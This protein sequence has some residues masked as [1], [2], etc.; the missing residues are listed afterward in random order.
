MTGQRWASPAQGAPARLLVGTGLVIGLLIGLR[1]DGRVAV[2]LVSGQSSAAGTALAGSPSSPPRALPPSEG[3]G[4]AAVAVSA[5]G[6]DS[7]TTGMALDYRLVLPLCLYRGE[8]AAP[9]RPLP[10][11]TAASTVTTPPSASA[12][13]TATTTPT[14]TIT[15]LATVTPP[16]TASPTVELPPPELGFDGDR[17]MGYA[18]AQCDLGPRP[19]G[20]AAHWRTGELI[21]DTLRAE[22]WDV[23]FDPL[24]YRGT[25]LRNVIARKGSG[26]V[27]MVGAHYD[28]RAAAD[29]DPDP[30][31]RNEPIVGANDGAS[32]V[33]VLM[34]LGRVLEAGL[35]GH[36][37]WLAFFDAEDQGGVNGWEWFV[38]S[39][40][41]AASIA[42]RPEND[43]KGLVLIDMV[44]SLDQRLCR[45]PD[46]TPALAD[47]VYAVAKTLGYAPWLPPDCLAP[48]GSDDH[49]RF[50]DLGLPAM[51]MI[52]SDYFAYW[53][54]HADTCDKIGALPLARV[55][56]TL[57]FWLESGAMW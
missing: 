55:G 54:T 17:A 42:R 50:L 27:I 4:S 13:S 11:R 24:Q 19:P 31:R 36:E 1:T 39:R 46:S 12:T 43:F 51:D 23:A 33:A 57:E 3:K 22:G 44:G 53:H 2:G 49:T 56:R 40:E 29:R 35:V 34:E 47:A 5:T 16:A 20:S 30:S 41:V 52:E 18:Q 28:T 37:V 14:V 9:P 32:G 8:P 25:D 45:M 7:S 6:A 10:T 26:P 21:S 15:P 38:G 48:F